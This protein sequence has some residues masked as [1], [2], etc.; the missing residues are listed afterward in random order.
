MK[1]RR[2]LRRRKQ[3]T[4]GK[5][6]RHNKRTRRT[7]GGVPEDPNYSNFKQLK[8]GLEHGTLSKDEIAELVNKIPPDYQYEEPSNDQLDYAAQLHSEQYGTPLPAKKYSLLDL[9]NLHKSKIDPALIKNVQERSI[10]NV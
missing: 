4:K 1:S 7:R 9:L 5:G 3:G 2:N 8:M 6:T 10:T